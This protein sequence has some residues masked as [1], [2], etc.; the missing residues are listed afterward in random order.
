MTDDEIPVQSLP[1][2]YSCAALSMHL[3]SGV[4]MELHSPITICPINHLTKRIWH[5]TTLFLS[6][7]KE[8]I[9]HVSTFKKKWIKE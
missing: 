7:E 5:I 9:S 3:T 1:S 2:Y 4:A 6:Y 8:P